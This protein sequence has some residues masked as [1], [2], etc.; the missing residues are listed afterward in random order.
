MSFTMWYVKGPAKNLNS[1]PSIGASAA[2]APW[3]LRGT[4]YPASYILTDVPPPLPSSNVYK[5][6]VDCPPTQSWRVPDP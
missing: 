2:G 6:A 4:T 3:M 1:E 5:P